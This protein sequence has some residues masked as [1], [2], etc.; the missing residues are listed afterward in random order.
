MSIWTGI[1]NAWTKL[2]AWVASLMPGLK[3]ELVALLGFIGSAAGSLQ[4]YVT[5][6]PLNQLMTS[7]QI[8]ITS[9]VL[10]SLVFWFRGIGDRVSAR[11]SS[12][13]S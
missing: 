7:T 12:P 9:A 1:Y 3:T 13:T 10:F 6:L 2:E 5:G 4:E 8:T 11:V